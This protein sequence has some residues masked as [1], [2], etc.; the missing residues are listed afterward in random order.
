L[1]EKYFGLFAHL[2]SYAVS[3]QYLFS[4]QVLVMNIER[5]FKL[6]SRLVGYLADVAVFLCSTGLLDQTKC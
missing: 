3:H 4:L 2:I 1:V 5:C 6:T